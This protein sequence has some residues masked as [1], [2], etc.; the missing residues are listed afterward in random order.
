[1]RVAALRDTVLEAGKDTAMAL[2]DRRAAMRVA[3]RTAALA[4][5]FTS[6]RVQA[7]DERYGLDVYV[8][9]SIHPV[10]RPVLYRNQRFVVYDLR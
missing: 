4:E 7:L 10:D 5:P 1:V 9:E 6:A 8:A 3:E 2:Y